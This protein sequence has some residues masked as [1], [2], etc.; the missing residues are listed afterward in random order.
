MA[1]ENEKPIIKIKLTYRILI[2]SG[3]AAPFD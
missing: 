2:A 1:K 3:Q